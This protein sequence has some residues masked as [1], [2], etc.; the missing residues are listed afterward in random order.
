VTVQHSF[1]QEDELTELPTRYRGQLLLA[2]ESLLSP[3][4][5]QRGDGL[6]NLILLKGHL[7]S[8]AATAVLATRLLEPQ[9][10]LRSTI[11]AALSAALRPAPG[12]ARPPQV[13]RRWLRFQLA[14]MRQ[15]EVYGL[16]RL[17]VEYE[18]QFSEVCNLLNACSYAGESLEAI[19][20]DRTVEVGVRAIAARAIGEVGFIDSIPALRDLSARLETRHDR[21]LGMGFAPEPDS[22]P[23]QLLPAVREALADLE[24]RV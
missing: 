10:R 18:E 1:I 12:A 14:E 2:L 19:L 4:P 21:Q 23:Q 5:E 16:L 22:E 20:G 15:P 8:P 13:V 7:R 11:V 17:V 6:E 24:N 9:F 3:D